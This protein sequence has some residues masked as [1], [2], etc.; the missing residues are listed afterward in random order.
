[1]LDL[2]LRAIEYASHGSP[3]NEALIRTRLD[4]ILM[5][6]LADEKWSLERRRNTSTDS[7]NLSN[8]S[9]LESVRK[10]T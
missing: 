7:T 3:E 2:V 6:S 10:R 5:L 4:V 9:S 1:M 8:R